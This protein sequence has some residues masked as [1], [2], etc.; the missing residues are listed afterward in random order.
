MSPIAEIGKNIKSSGLVDVSR[1]P[2]SRLS[3]IWRSPLHDFPIRDQILYQWL[4]LSRTAS[5]LEI[6][7]GTGITA[8]RLS[9][10]VSNVTS[11]DISER[12]I[13]RLQKIYYGTA[14]INFVCAD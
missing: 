11:V 8:L 1:R 3:D 9:H 13:E 12:N 7:S 14:N 4:P 10:H 5:V 2:A 6:G